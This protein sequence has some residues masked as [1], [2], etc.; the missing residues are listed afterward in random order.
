MGE[1]G[2][3]N[4][5]YV[6]TVDGEDIEGGTDKNVDILLEGEQYHFRL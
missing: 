4:I 2:T 6:G 3:V 5:D 1:T